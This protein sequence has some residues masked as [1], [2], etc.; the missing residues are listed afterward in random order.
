MAPK[1][2]Q[3]GSKFAET[4][5]RKLGMNTVT[6]KFKIR[7]EYGIPQFLTILSPIMIF[8]LLGAIGV[9]WLERIY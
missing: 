2:L 1:W 9:Q 5:N 8:G 7:S 4:T 6:R 3:N